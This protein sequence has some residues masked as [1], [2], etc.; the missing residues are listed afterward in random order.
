MYLFS[1]DKLC[2]KEI[3]ADLESG[4]GITTL[5]ESAC[6]LLNYVGDVVR[7]LCPPSPARA[8]SPPWEGEPLLPPDPETDWM[9]DLTHDDDD[10]SGGDE[11]VSHYFL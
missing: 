6:Y 4:G 5:V 1:K 7:A 10:E 11:S 2:E 9:E 3:L 8:T